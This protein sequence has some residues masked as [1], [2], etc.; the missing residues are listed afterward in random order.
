MI[1]EPLLG[2]SSTLWV[3]INEIRNAITIMDVD[4]AIRDI[5]RHRQTFAYGVEGM[6]TLIEAG[7]DAGGPLKPLHT[8][9]AGDVVHSS[10][11]L[12]QVESNTQ[13]EQATKNRL[14]MQLVVG[15]GD[16]V[17]SQADSWP[18]NPE[19]EIQFLR[20]IRNGAAHNNRLRFRSKADPRPNT[21]WKGFAITE[22]M[23]GDVIFTD[24]SDR[25]WESEF[26]EI[27]KG[28]LEAGDALQLT[29]DIL[30]LLLPKSE[31]YGPANVIGISEGDFSS[32]EHS[33]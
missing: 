29:T 28:F 31:T 32:R 33:N 1:Y 14:G 20:Q 7:I 21:E 13:L 15:V 10:Y 16:S 9:I 4:R 18:D 19:P 3:V 27:E 2:Y 25:A 30:E 24:V 23:E 5:L 12:P 6:H 11:I 22:D 8:N 26:I 17:K